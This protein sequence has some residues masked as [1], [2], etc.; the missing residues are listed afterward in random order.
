MIAEF[1]QRAADQSFGMQ[2]LT[3]VVFVA[4]LVVVI[5]VAVVIITMLTDSIIDLYRSG[6][7]RL[8]ERRERQRQ[9]RVTDDAMREA[10]KKQLYAAVRQLVEDDQRRRLEFASKTG[11][12]S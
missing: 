3:G 6:E 9:E 11:S 8:R 4:A 2:V 5:G 12:R 7:T 1:F 10:D